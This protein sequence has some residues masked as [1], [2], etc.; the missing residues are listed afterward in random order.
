M[1]ELVKFERGCS[2]CENLEKV[3]KGTYRCST[4]LHLDDT[5]ILP[6]E[7][8]KRT[9]DWGICNGKY[10]KREHTERRKLCC[11]KSC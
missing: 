5:D 4:R 9:K 10:Y 11:Q 8:G 2:K 7:D 1:G 6:I 3:G